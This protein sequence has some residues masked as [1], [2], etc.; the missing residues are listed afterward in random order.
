MAIKIE[1]F[2]RQYPV[3]T[4]KIFDDHINSKSINTTKNTL[5]HHIRQGHIVRIKRGLFASIPYGADPT[6]YPINPYLVASYLSDDA[7]IGYHTALSYYGTAYSISHRFI[8][9]TETKNRTLKFHG[10]TYQPTA[11]PTTLISK[12]QTHCYVNTE[13][14]QGLDALITSKERTLVDVLDRPLLGGGWEEIWRSLDMI[15][16]LNIEHVVEYTLKLDVATTVAKV[17]LY[18]EQRQK[19]LNIPEEVLRELQKHIPSSPCYLENSRNSK[20]KLV[21]RWNLMVPESLIYKYWEE[22]LS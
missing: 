16:Y 1:R 5:S 4:R 12:E 9:L 7:V 20:S 3:F 19:E 22:S 8:Y 21:N 17:G 13:D 6:T 11:F 14:V 18:L 10:V 2:F 15:Q